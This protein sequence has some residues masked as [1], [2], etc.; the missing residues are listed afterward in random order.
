M[1]QRSKHVPLIIYLTILPAALTHLCQSGLESVYIVHKSKRKVLLKTPLPRRATATVDTV[2]HNSNQRGKVSL[3]LKL[4]HAAAP[5]SLHTSQRLMRTVFPQPNV[6]SYGWYS[7]VILLRYCAVPRCMTTWSGSV[8]LHCTAHNVKPI[9]QAVCV[10]SVFF[11]V[12]WV[13]LILTFTSM[14]FSKQT[15]SIKLI[16]SCMLVLC[17]PKK[18]PTS[19]Y[20]FRT[21]RT[22][23]VIKWQW[24]YSTY[25]WYSNN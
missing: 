12:L 19:H 7:V 2:F 16:T 11:K 24:V 8:F 25:I 22:A 1:G 21:A 13:A 15:I 10:V 4:S 23:N 6:F 14:F 5:C 20:M 3:I 18:R 9:S 17:F